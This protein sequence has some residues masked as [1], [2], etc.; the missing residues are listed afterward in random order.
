MT[1]YNH[2]VTDA[3]RHAAS[4]HPISWAARAGLTA[5]GVVYILIGI[6]ALLIDAGS[7]GQADQKGALAKLM[8]QPY[9]KWL[10]LLIAI[11]LAAY[12]LW[13]LSE[14]AFGV[15]GEKPGAMARVKSL[16]RGV[17]YAFFAYTAVKVL[18]GSRTAQSTQQRSYAAQVL[19]HPWGKWVLAIV[20]LI[21]VLVGLGAI[22][23]GLSQRFMRYFPVGGMSR[24]ARE[25]V[26]ALGTVGITARGV[27]FGVVGYL[28][29]SA[30]WTKQPRKAGGFDYALKTVRHLPL[31]S[32]WLALIGI[33][34]IL[35]GLYG[36][37]EARY[38]R[39]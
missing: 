9:G 5:R 34:L 30:A 26:R 29:T 33:G 8:A 20:G 17:I 4:G 16:V 15:T 13:R 2:P 28:V 32:L 11:G 27:V 21:V 24:R 1:S 12:S 7:S 36:L 22:A 37:A 23:E 19:A 31:G 35:F 10:V 25:A 39:V 3:V 38:R 6:T 14:A 18:E